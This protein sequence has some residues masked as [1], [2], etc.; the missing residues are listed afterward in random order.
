MHNAPVHGG[1]PERRETPRI[2]VLGRLDGHIETVDLTVRV[3]EIGLGGFSVESPCGFP[4]DAEH[5]F[6]LRLS[7]G[8]AVTVRARAVHT[9]RRP[10]GGDA[11]YITGFLFVQTPNREATEAIGLVIDELTAALQF[12]D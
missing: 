2:D 1:R 9:Y 12:H 8:G 4:V 11:P 6:R 7:S 10:D 5:D 3:R